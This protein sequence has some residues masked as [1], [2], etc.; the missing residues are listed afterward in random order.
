MKTVTEIQ[1]TNNTPQRFI[2]ILTKVTEPCGWISVKITLIKYLNY[3]INI[4]NRGALRAKM[5]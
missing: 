5:E 1:A 4:K 3:Y 2:Y